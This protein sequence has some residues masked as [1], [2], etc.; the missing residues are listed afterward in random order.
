MK[1][2]NNV[3]IPLI[4]Q[5]PRILLQNY[6]LADR[7]DPANPVAFIFSLISLIPQKFNFFRL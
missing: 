7:A 4:M 2:I 5:I 3:S 1:R 6:V